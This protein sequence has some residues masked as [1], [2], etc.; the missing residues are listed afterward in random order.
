[1]PD[2]GEHTKAVLAG[3]GFTASEIERLL[4]AGV[5]G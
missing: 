1:L 3:Y 2:V 5:V 4:G